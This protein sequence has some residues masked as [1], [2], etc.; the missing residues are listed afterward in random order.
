MKAFEGRRGVIRTVCPKCVSGYWGE[1]GLE[2][3]D[4]QEARRPLGMQA[5]RRKREGGLSPV[6]GSRRGRSIS[7]VKGWPWDTGIVRGKRG[8]QVT[9]GVWPPWAQLG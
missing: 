6:K 1:V 2:Q 3:G 5:G 4:A 8:R 7:E 9:S